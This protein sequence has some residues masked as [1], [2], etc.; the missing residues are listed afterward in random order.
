MN[1]DLV[2]EH[3]RLQQKA[4]RKRL[5]QARDSHEALKGQ[6][7]KARKNGQ[8][9]RPKTSAASR[10]IPQLN[11]LLPRLNTS[12]SK[13]HRLPS[14]IKVFLRPHTGKM[15]DRE[16]FKHRNQLFTLFDERKAKGDLLES[17]IK[18]VT[19]PLKLA[20]LEEGLLHK[21]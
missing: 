20:K 2:L 13:S 10:E 12:R 11:P 16:K 1:E 8:Q 3:S 18:E 7:R 15:G 6:K 5:K 19:D 17:R 14:P 4:A 9:N 21:K